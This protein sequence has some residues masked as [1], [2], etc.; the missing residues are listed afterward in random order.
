MKRNC[1][2]LQGEKGKEE[3]GSV[4]LTGDSY[5]V[6]REELKSV[7]I[8]MIIGFVIG[9]GVAVLMFSGDEKTDLTTR[10]EIMVII[11][12]LVSGT[13]YVWRHFPYIA[14]GWLALLLKVVVSVFV[15]WFVTP[16]VLFLKF[17]QMKL[18][19]GSL[20]RQM[21]RE[22]PGIV[23]TVGYKMAGICAIVCVAVSIGIWPVIY[24]TG[25]V[26]G[27]TDLFFIIYEIY[28][29]ITSILW[30]VYRTYSIIGVLDIAMDCVITWILRHLWIFFVMLISESVEIPYMIWIVLFGM[31][32]FIILDAVINSI[33]FLINSK[34]TVNIEN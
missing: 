24:I 13:P 2:K 11:G 27:R 20:L 16:L 25:V 33:K 10:I 19:E 32:G 21:Q 7:F 18:Y 31:D 30:V 22:N 1:Y 34:R 9:V 6:T 26:G 8:S 29:I 14:L 3:M 15:G 17:I 5:L 28:I 23:G 12:L 4:E